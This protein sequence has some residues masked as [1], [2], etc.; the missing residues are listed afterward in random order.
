MTLPFESACNFVSLSLKDANLCYDSLRLNSS[1]SSRFLVQSL[2]LF[3]ITQTSLSY[4]Y[5]SKLIYILKSVQ[6][7]LYLKTLVLRTRVD[8]SEGGRQWLGSKEQNRSDFEV[9]Q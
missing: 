5:C 3:K 7:L 4:I 6:H 2:L 1:I 8:V 9:F